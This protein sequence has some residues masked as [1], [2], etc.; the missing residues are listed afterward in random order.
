[1]FF[2]NSKQMKNELDNLKR[3]VENLTAQIQRMQEESPS[4]G[5]DVAEWMQETEARVSGNC[6]RIDWLVK[7]VVALKQRIAK[8]E[9]K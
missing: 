3:Q 2:N 8:L 6:T 5:H 9:N 1:M 7:E 4:E